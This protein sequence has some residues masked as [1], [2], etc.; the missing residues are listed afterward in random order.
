MQTNRTERILRMTGASASA[1]A[2]ALAVVAVLSACGERSTTP[3]PATR[4]IEAGWSFGFCLG[5]CTGAL[6]VEGDDLSYRVASRTGDEVLARG[7]GELTSSGVSRLNALLSALP[8]DLLETYG[9]PDCADAGAAY[10]VL[11][12]DAALHRS[13]Y[14][15]PRPPG[16]LAALDAFLREVM[17]ALGSCQSNSQ[18]RIAGG[19]TPVPE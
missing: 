16:E 2:L 15:Y 19:C 17:D 13:V 9:C 18:I 5:P 12:R 3:S 4:L 10:V 14:E 11:R 7:H 8:P 6:E 1:G